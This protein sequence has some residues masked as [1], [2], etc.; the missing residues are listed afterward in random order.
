MSTGATSNGLAAAKRL[1][2]EL[3]QTAPRRMGSSSN[4]QYSGGRANIQA[5]EKNEFL[6]QAFVRKL[7]EAIA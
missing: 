6:L 1:R 3:Q 5:A 7:F 2:R 4:I